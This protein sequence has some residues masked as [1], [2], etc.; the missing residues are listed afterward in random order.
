MI[1]MYYGIKSYRN[2]I[3]FLL[4]CVSFNLNPVMVRY[5][6]L[7]LLIFCFDIGFEA[8][9]K[10]E[11]MDKHFYAFICFL[12]LFLPTMM[13]NIEIEPTLKDFIK[14]TI[15]YFYE[16]LS[17]D[18]S[19][20]ILYQYQHFPLNFPNYANFSKNCPSKSYPSHHVDVRMSS[21]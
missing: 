5:S 15:I 3:C 20:L 17:N 19:Y 9:D 10:F 21:N 6:L 8:E 16:M 11:M 18:Y 2:S 12:Y 1:F 4:L 13:I 14:P 7:R